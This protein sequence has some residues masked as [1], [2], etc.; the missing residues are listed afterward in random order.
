M[1]EYTDHTPVVDA[2]QGLPRWVTFALLAAIVVIFAIS[3][4]LA[5]R[6]SDADAE[7][8]GGTDS[9]VTEILEEGGVE[10][11]FEP[12][13]QPESGEIESGLFAMQAALGAGILGYALGNL[14]GRRTTTDALA[15]SDHSTGLHR[16][17]E[18]PARRRRDE[19]RRP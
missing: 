10:P 13:F 19:P 4:A 15:S 8:F 1:S 7:A 6:P 3:F 5:P 17:T 12:F 14:R 16:G 18:A 11:W 9:V 2:R